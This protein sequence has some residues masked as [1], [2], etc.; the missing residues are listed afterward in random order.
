MTMKEG[1]AKCPECESGEVV[2]QGRNEQGKQRYQCKN[3]G[4]EKNLF[5]LDYD[6]PGCRVEIQRKIVEMALNGNGV[7]DTGRLLNSD[8]NTVVNTLKKKRKAS[9]TLIINS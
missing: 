8:K 5:L 2:K 9:K 7:R 1:K 3:K 6:Y 4:C